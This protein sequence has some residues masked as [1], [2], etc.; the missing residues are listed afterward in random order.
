MRIE[1]NDS[2]THVLNENGIN[3]T[4]N[5]A[6]WGKAKKPNIT[7]TSSYTWASSPE[8]V[9]TKPTPPEN[10]HITSINMVLYNYALDKNASDVK[11]ISK[12]EGVKIVNY[13][14]YVYDANEDD[15]VP[16]QGTIKP[17]I[18][19]R[20]MV[21]IEPEDGYDFEGLTKNN[22]TLSDIGN[23]LKEKIVGGTSQRKETFELPTWT[24]PVVPKE[25]KLTFDTDGGSSIAPITQK[26]GST[27]ILS[28]YVPTKAGHDFDGWY[29]DAQRTE[30]IKQ[31]TLNK[32]MTVY[33][34]W[35]AKQ[36]PPAPPEEFTITVKPNGGN[37][38][39]DATDKTIKVKKGE[40]FTLPDAPT[41]NGYTFLYWKGSE[42]H[43]GDPYQVNENHTFTAEWKANT[44]TPGGSSSENPPVVPGDTSSEKPPVVPGGSSSENP[45][46]NPGTSSSSSSSSEQK[47]AGSTHSA[48]GNR[49]NTKNAK[50]PKTGDNSTS[51]LYVCTSLVAAAGLSLLRRKEKTQ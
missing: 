8:Y 22:I 37:W 43:P 2:K 7:P 50:S 17:E 1:G 28:P 12:T 47:P 45:P 21:T 51:L 30:K 42:Y 6:S 25:Y 19:Y 15:W 34:K 13:G 14:L 9:I 3:I 44:V 10:K 4:V 39:G 24:A 11:P 27:I 29:K 16:V 18:S 26:E 31:V 49:D 48:E 40:F 38:N 32:D 33:A 23:P 20:L 35:T 46:V 5:G 36:N 41:R